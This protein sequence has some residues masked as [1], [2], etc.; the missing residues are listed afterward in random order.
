MTFAQHVRE[1]LPAALHLPKAFA[2]VFDWAEAAG[3]NATFPKGQPFLSIYPLDQMNEPGASYL[4]F[5]PE[6]PPLAKPIPSE[7][8]ERYATIAT[9]AGDGGKMGFWLDDTGTQQI[10][11]FDHGWPFVLTD[12]PI[13]ALQFLSIGYPEPAA[14]ENAS[15]LLREAVEYQGSEPPIVPTAFQEF[16]TNHFGVDVPLRCSDLGL[17]IPEFEDMSDPMRQWMDRVRPQ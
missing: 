15:F 12:D 6:G 5:H 13:K 10:V 14:L 8:C 16:I 17:F 11:I 3:Q 9:A 2:D 4:I 7:I 1:A